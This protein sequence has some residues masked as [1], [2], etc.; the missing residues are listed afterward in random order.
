MNRRVSNAALSNAALV[1]S[2]K[3]WKIF[4]MG[5]ASKINPKCFGPAFSLAVRESMLL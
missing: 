4:E 2:S 1:L 3:N 5:A